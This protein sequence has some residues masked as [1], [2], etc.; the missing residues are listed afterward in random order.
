MARFQV[1]SNKKVEIIS[2][3]DAAALQRYKVYRKLLNDENWILLDTVN[4]G[5]N[6][7][8]EALTIPAIYDIVCEGFWEYENPKDWMRS[9][10]N[11][12]TGDGGKLIVIQCEDYWS[13][14]NDWND[15]VVT[16]KII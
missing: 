6:K 4:G 1:D 8:Y 13:T 11:I 15:M 12:S 3:I 5:Q 16:I 14:D 7:F 10:E 9:R 2:T